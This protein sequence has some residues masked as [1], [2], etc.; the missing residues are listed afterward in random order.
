MRERDG[1][2]LHVEHVE[3]LRGGGEGHRL[4]EV[5]FTEILVEKRGTALFDRQTTFKNNYLLS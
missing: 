1:L 5:A 3:H 2:R 4:S